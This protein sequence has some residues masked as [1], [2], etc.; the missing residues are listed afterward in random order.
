MKSSIQFP[1]NVA[2]I[3]NN[4]LIK[5]LWHFALVCL[6]CTMSFGWLWKPKHYLN[7]PSFPKRSLV[8]FSCELN[9]QLLADFCLSPPSA[10]GRIA[11]V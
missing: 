10:L 4:D 7:H 2:R 3:A 6:S 8:A 1:F 9:R 5:I 11:T